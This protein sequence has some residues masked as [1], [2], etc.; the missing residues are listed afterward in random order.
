MLEMAA[1]KR[2]LAVHFDAS[3]PREVSG[4]E[5]QDSKMPQTDFNSTE[6]KYQ[7]ESTE[8][9]SGAPVGIVALMTDSTSRKQNLDSWFAVSRRTSTRI[10][11]ADAGRLIYEWS[12]NK[13]WAENPKLYY[14]FRAMDREDLFAELLRAQ[15]TDLWLPLSTSV[16]KRLV[17]P[18]DREQ[19]L[20]AQNRILDAGRLPKDLRAQHLSIE[21][22]DSMEL[23]EVKHLGTGGFAKVHH[24]RDPRTKKEYARKV[25]ER[26][27][28]FNRQ[29]EMMKSFRKEVMGM[30]RVQHLHCITLLATWTD[31]DSVG[32][33]FS[34]VADMDLAKY[35]DEDLGLLQ[36]DVLHRAVGCITS[37]LAYL[38]H[39]NI[40]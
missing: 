25:M 18:P 30:R 11:F 20:D 10:D 1:P 39:L 24:I 27:R 17:K 8:I 38:H 16:M 5:L 31:M 36:L 6:R 34:P 28:G 37:A 2:H 29:C 14:I 22:S 26:S 19:Y 9:S 33:L 23:E 7:F 21:D 35:L 40:R 13:S 32:L 3:Q 12:G 4:T 15:V